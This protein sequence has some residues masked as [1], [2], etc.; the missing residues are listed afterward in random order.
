LKDFGVDMESRKGNFWKYDR[1][2]NK[3]KF[4]KTFLS[5]YETII[6][7]LDHTLFNE[8]EFLYQSYYEFL[9]NVDGLE[10]K[11][12]LRIVNHAMKLVTEGKR[13]QLYQSLLKKFS[14]LRN[15]GLDDFLYFLRENK[16]KIKLFSGVQTFLTFLTKNNKQVFILTNGNKEQQKNKIKSLK[17]DSFIKKERI[18]FAIGKLRKPSPLGI[19]RILDLSR[20]NEEVCVF[21]GD[22]L[23]DE[24]AS[25][26]AKIDFISIES[27][28]PKKKYK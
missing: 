22:S 7:D 1:T 24:K 19:E 21:I 18:L 3:S 28:F 6:F 10:E 20:S 23:E 15:T 25:R 17:L 16:K 12:R 4:A 27:L 13:E 26:K 5:K 14:L 9:I 11:D 2:F 8:Y